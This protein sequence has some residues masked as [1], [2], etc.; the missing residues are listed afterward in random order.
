MRLTVS[1]QLHELAAILLLLVGVAALFRPL[2]VLATS[3]VSLRDVV[4]P[5]L[6]DGHYLG[7][8][9]NAVELR[10]VH[11]IAEDGARLLMLS[12]RLAAPRVLLTPSITILISF[13]TSHGVQING[14]Y[15][16]F[17]IFNL[18]HVLN[19]PCD[20][21]ATSLMATGTLLVLCDT[22]IVGLD[23]LLGE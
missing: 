2:R 13:T 21:T 1:L 5:E 17:P 7:L 20:Q 15:D 16:L 3:A 8:L 18:F 19:T 14:G 23:L 22:Q 10:A 4:I 9:V 12:V 11:V 6:L